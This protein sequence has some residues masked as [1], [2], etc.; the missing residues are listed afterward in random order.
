MN[1]KISTRFR[2]KGQVLLFGGQHFLS[3]CR[4]T[5][6]RCKLPLLLPVLSPSYATNFHAEKSRNIFYFP[7]HENLLRE[8]VVIWATTL[9]ACN[10]TL[11]RDKLIENVAL[12]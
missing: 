8:E 5:M 10:A 2:N 7:Q 9:A 1:K 11:L 12:E 6:L 4:A 3:T